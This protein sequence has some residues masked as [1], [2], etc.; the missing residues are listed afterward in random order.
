M[1]LK[2]CPE[3]DHQ[4][5]KSAMQCPNC[6]HIIRKPKRGFFG[7]IFKW[8]F[9]LFNLFMLVWMFSFGD[10]VVKTDTT[11][12]SDAETAGTAI[13]AGLGFTFQLI[14]WLVGGFILGLFTLFTRAK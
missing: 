14:V 3:C 8:T 13:G 7:K 1:A 11:Y 5:S 10:A 6:G 12:M 9:I 4:V 2:N